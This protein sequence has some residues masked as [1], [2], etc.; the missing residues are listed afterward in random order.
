MLGE[1]PKAGLRQFAPPD[2]AFY[3]YVDVGNLTNDSE[4][5]CRRMLEETGVAV[6]PGTDFDSGRGHR[7]LRISF[8]GSTEDMAE[9]AQRLIRWLA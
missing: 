7:S 1:L 6:T 5:F 2:G 4:A 3:L 9:A 8:A